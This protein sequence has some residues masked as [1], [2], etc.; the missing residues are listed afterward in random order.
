MPDLVGYHLLLGW[1]VPDHLAAAAR[2]FRYHRRVFVAPPWPQIYT[3][4]SERNQDF[5]EAVRTH[6]AMVTAYTQ[7]GYELSALPLGD[8]ATRRAFVER[9][10]V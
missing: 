8:V 9:M 10:A 5:T 2:Q 4:D 7:L 6:D 3:N 1:P